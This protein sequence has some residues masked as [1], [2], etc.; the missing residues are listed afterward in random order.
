M[1]FDCEVTGLRDKKRSKKSKIKK[2]VF[3][4]KLILGFLQLFQNAAVVY[5]F[6]QK[7]FKKEKHS[8]NTKKK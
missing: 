6:Y 4:I 7:F 2:F 3:R 5:Y 1:I 8:R